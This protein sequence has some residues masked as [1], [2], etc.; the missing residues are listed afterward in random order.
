[1]AGA[2]TISLRQV[3]AV[4]LGNALE[5]FDFLSYAFF[6]VYIGRTFFPSADSTASLLASL[7][8]FGAGFL[9]RPIGALVLGRLGDRIGRK[10]TM[11]FSFATMGVAMLGIALTPSYAAIGITAPILVIIFRLI[12]GFALGGE[13][14][15][16]TTFLVEAAPADRR[17]LYVSLQK[18]GQDAAFLV[19]GLLGFGLSYFLSDGQLSS[20]GWRVVFVVGALTVPL[21]L[22]LRRS[23]PETL[24]HAGDGQPAVPVR[25]YLRL[26]VLATLILAPLSVAT[27]LLSYLT[28]YAIQTLKMPATLA[29]GAPIALGICGMIFDPVSGWLSDR[30]G[31]KPVMIVPWAALLV[32]VVPAFYALDH[33]RTA[34][35]LWL[36][37]GLL[38]VLTT[39]AVTSAIVLLTESL[40]KAVRC[41]GVAIVYALATSVFGGSSQFVVTWLIRATGSPL[42]LAWYMLATGLVGLVAMILVAES[43]P[44][45]RPLQTGPAREMAGAG[46]NA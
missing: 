9:T 22:V 19:A 44:A 42:A 29:F 40:P 2:P 43:V 10:P 18:V 26:A 39:A 37:A 46:E 41:G 27:Y 35:F 38:Q 1:M 30:I 34:G 14:G 4:A 21:G 31:R 12:Q 6:A 20:W 5:F 3:S 32:I 45:R 16:S 33:Y 15:S 25:S 24:E 11:I 23:L 7:A 36:F 13:V 28:T 17:G 8:T